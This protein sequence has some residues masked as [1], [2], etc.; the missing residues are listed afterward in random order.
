[1]SRCC[2]GFGAG[3]SMVCGGLMIGR[4]VLNRENGGE[5]QIP[6]LTRVML[7]EIEALLACLRRSYSFV[8][9]V[10]G[11]GGDYCVVV[12]RMRSW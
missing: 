3:L 11:I 5:S 1:M 4:L 12:V 6:R 9:Q 8:M 10:A 7:S 2:G